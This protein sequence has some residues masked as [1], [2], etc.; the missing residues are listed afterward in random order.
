MTA[1]KARSILDRQPPKMVAEIELLDDRTKEPDTHPMRVAFIRS[2]I[3]GYADHFGIDR[4][5]WAYWDQRIALTKIGS[6][7]PL[8]RDADEE[9]RDKELFSQSVRVIERGSNL[10]KPIMNVRRSLMAILSDYAFYAIRLYV[11]IPPQNSASRQE[12]ADYINQ[13]L[14]ENGISL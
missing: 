6:H 14:R 7:V 2:R 11:L 12:I 4:N 9:A 8:G 3:D 13:D 10:S 5:L 1:L